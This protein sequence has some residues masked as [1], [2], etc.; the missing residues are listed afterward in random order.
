MATVHIDITDQVIE[1]L[2][3]VLARQ[4]AMAAV[5]FGG[6]IPSEFALTLEAWLKGILEHNIA[7][8]LAEVT[9]TPEADEA[10]QA[11]HHAKL[12]LVKAV[13]GV[14]SVVVQK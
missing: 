6:Q 14:R 7:S 11:L 8:V 3:Q 2:E 1:E 5:Q 13:S 10:R 9:R 12:A 4:A